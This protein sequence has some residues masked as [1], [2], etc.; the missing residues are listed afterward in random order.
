MHIS[1]KQVAWR[2]LWAIVIYFLEQIILVNVFS[3]FLI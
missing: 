2:D 3:L 1:S